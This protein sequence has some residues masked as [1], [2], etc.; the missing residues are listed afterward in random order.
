MSARSGGKAEARAP[1]PRR[2]RRPA[3]LLALLG[4]SPLVLPAALLTTLSSTWPA[5]AQLRG[6]TA[7]AAPAE[8]GLA[9][10][11]P[12]EA[13]ADMDG[14]GS[15]AGGGAGLRGMRPAFRAP[16]GQSTLGQSTLGSSTLGQAQ[17]SRNSGARPPAGSLPTGATEAGR[18]GA[19]SGGSAAGL[20]SGLG[21]DPSSGLSSGFGGNRPPARAG[22]IGASERALAELLRNRAAPARRSGSAT[23]R[24]TRETTQRP[25]AADRLTPVVRS[26]VSGVPLPTTIPAPIL[27][28]VTPGLLLANGLRPPLQVDE[29]YAPLGLRLGGLTLLPA[30]SQSLGYDTNPNQAAGTAA[31]GSVALRSEAELGFRSDWSAAELA[32][33][34]RGAYLEYPQNESASRPSAAG[35]VRLGVDA[36]RDLRLDAEGRFLVDTQRVGSIDLQATNATSRPLI[37]AYGAS[38]GATQR[39]NRLSVSLRGQFDRS[40]FEDARLG[41]GT[42]VVQSDRNLNQY[43]V[44]LRTAYEVSPAFTPF[45]DALADIRVYDTARDVT[46]LRRDSTGVALTAGAAFSLG[47]ALSGE[48][49]GG[50]QHRTYPDP[51][52]ADVNAPLLSAALTWQ[53][54]PLTAVRLGAQSTVSETTLRGSSGAVTEAATLE[55]QHDLFRNLSIVLGAAVLQNS[56]Q[57][58]TTRETG[59]SATARVDYRFTRWLTLRG[60]YLYQQID[61]TVANVSFH[62]NTFLLGLRVNP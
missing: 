4:A 43:G 10:P 1:G 52:L 41:D 7:D 44:R 46:G 2:A 40:T 22:S 54:S 36:S 15:G 30:F 29:A 25:T 18:S 31:R 27:G 26:A 51:A 38:L 53:L 5:R 55:V 57:G 47:A 28:L 49:S 11:A 35:T 32:G 60:T 50:L 9:E 56:Y 33:D 17:G 58:T 37:M 42:T 39:F 45:V 61:S 59:F 24:T 14:A 8:P 16:F 62:G 20:A 13:D 48:I 19:A 12:A 3:L 6:S 21:S 23:R 34:L